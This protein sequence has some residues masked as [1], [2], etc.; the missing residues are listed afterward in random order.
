[1]DKENNCWNYNV[2]KEQSNGKN[3]VSKEDSAKQNKG[4][5]SDIRIKERKW[6]SLGVYV[7]GQIYIPNNK[8]IQE[9]VL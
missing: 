3:K 4:T 9:Q 2:E 7:N 8:K 5:R 6:T 1:M